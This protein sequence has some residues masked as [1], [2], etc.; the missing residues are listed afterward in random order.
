MGQYD[1]IDKQ[2]SKEIQGDVKHI[3][4]ARRAYVALAQ[5]QIRHDQQPEQAGPCVNKNMSNSETIR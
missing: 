4:M 3:R 2:V 1:G 5:E